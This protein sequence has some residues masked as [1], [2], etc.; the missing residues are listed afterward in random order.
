MIPPPEPCTN[1][2]LSALPLAERQHLQSHL[3]CV[4]LVRGQV[5]CE[6]GVLQRHVYF[7]TDAI[8][9]LCYLTDSGAPAEVAIV[10]NEGVVGVSLFLG[11]GFTTS[12]AVVEGAGQALRGAAHAVKDVFEQSMPVRQ[13][14][15]RYIQALMTQMAQLAACNRHHALEQRL[16]RHLLQRLDRM[17]GIDVATTQEQIA[18]ALG[19]RREGVTAAALKLQAAGLIRNARGHVSVLD[20]R[21]LMLRS[22]EC[23]AAVD[24]EYDRLLPDT[25]TTTPFQTGTWGVWTAHRGCHGPLGV[26]GLSPSGAT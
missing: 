19:V 6:P 5:L 12:R 11:G 2:L 26:D 21:Q 24:Q 13:A 9:S 1:R 23:Y 22:C 14:I 10:G 8:V 3:E 15:L 25:E 7:P 4:D 17:H 18:H 20:R 16:C